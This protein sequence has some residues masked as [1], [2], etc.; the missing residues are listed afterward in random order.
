MEDV[1]NVDLSAEAQFGVLKDV[2]LTYINGSNGS[3][4][5]GRTNID[6]ILDVHEVLQYVLN[7]RRI[8]A[9]GIDAFKKNFSLFRYV[10]LSNVS[11]SDCNIAGV[12]FTG[13]NANID[14]QV[15]LKKNMRGC[16]LN[17]LDFS[18]KSF[19][20]VIVT[21][22]DFS[23]ASNVSLDPQTVMFKSL[24]GCVLNG[25]DFMDKSFVSVCLEDAD[26]R[27]AKNVIVNRHTVWN[28]NLSSTLFDD[29]AVVFDES[30][31]DSDIA[32]L[33]KKLNDAF[34]NSKTR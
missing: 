18:G 11:F 8:D 12:D 4:L 15:V 13:T 32:D 10:D 31:V 21:C 20:G 23:G 28:R 33:R 30:K 7:S 1:R 6:G 14:P 17:G 25:I 34:C 26:L 29:S 5:S 27:G 9:S 24:Y 2:I 16:K 3:D 22:C 19:D